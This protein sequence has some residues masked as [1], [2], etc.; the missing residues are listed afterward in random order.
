MERRASI[1]A[2]Y[3]N[4]LKVRGNSDK[5]VDFLKDDE[6]LVVKALHLEISEFESGM[7]VS[8][9]ESL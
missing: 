3:L 4:G 1:H 9:L 2:D 6:S 8:S 5:L 7:T